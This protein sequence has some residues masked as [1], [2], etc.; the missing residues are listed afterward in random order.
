MNNFLKLVGYF[1]I[2]I[3]IIVVIFLVTSGLERS[4]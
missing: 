3:F 2:G 1:A 4:P